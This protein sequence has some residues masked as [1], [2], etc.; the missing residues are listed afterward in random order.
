MDTQFPVLRVTEQMTA[1]IRRLQRGG[2]S[3]AEI[4]DLVPFIA[5][6]YHS[7]PV[8]CLAYLDDYYHLHE[9]PIY[10]MPPKIGISID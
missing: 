1:A 3:P 10:R 8:D 6:Y 2:F 9:K 7:N 4:A 5:P